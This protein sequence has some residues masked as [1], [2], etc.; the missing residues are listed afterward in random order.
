MVVD[1]GFKKR[2]AANG[3]ADLG[4]FKVKPNRFANGGL[5]LIPFIVLVSLIFFCNAAE[6]LFIRQPF[7]RQQSF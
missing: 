6:I 5:F 4:I 1:Y 3:C 7:G 2:F